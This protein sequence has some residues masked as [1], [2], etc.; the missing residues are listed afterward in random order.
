MRERERDRELMT[1]LKDQIGFMKEEIKHK[2][3]II[4]TLINELNLS[5]FRSSTESIR[6]IIIKLS[7]TGSC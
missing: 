5:S 2:N 1:L 4:H 6:R 3:N 7:L